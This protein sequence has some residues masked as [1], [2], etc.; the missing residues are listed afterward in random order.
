MC[1]SASVC[2]VKALPSRSQGA[3]TATWKPRV[4]VHVCVRAFFKG[5]KNNPFDN[6]ATRVMDFQQLLSFICYIFPWILVKWP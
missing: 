6:V 3:T 4:C 1:V 5:S 2:L